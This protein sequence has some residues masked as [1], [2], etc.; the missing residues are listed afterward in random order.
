MS[1]RLRCS[2]ARSR[3]HY[4]RTSLNE[5]LRKGLERG[6]RSLSCPWS[7]YINAFDFLWVSVVF[8]W[9]L[10]TSSTVTC[11][12]MLEWCWAVNLVQTHKRRHWIKRDS[13]WT[14]SREWQSSAN[15][16]QQLKWDIIR[17]Q[18]LHWGKLRYFDRLWTLLNKERLRNLY[19]VALERGAYSAKENG[20]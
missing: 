14:V 4:H 6:H 18:Q 2:E 3:S 1:T 15:A 16:T 5:Q 13:F 12:D 7:T 11:D 19:F 8:L 20:E 17:I 9:A 10:R